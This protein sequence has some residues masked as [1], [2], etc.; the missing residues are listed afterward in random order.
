MLNEFAVYSM[1]NINSSAETGARNE[2]PLNIFREFCFH[3]LSECFFS[4]GFASGGA[5]VR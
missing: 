2:K 4:C 3:F 1:L 5:P